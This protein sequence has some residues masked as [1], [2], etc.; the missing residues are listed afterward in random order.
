MKLRS[1]SLALA[2]AALTGMIGCGGGSG[3][4]GSGPQPVAQ[5]GLLVH[6]QQ[7][8]EGG[9]FFPTPRPPQIRPLPGATVIVQQSGTGRQVTRAQTDQSGNCLLLLPPD[10]YRV[11]PLPSDPAASGLP[12]PLQTVVV[13]SGKLTPVTL[14]Y[15]ILAP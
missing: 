8:I 2:C 12:P 15:V 7:R 1:W 9:A 11:L 5:T 4:S 3:G 13:Q 6:V 10:T 14:T